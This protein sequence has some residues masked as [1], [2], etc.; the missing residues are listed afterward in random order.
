MSLDS[1]KDLVFGDEARS[2]LMEGVNLLA[3]AVKV[4]MGPKGQ[5]VV[6][7]RSGLPPHLTKDGVTVAQSINL[8]D[9]FP[10]LGV[11]MIKEAANRTAE[12]AGDGTTTATVLSQ[13]IVNEGLKVL[14][15]GYSSSE[16]RKGV[17]FAT[18]Q[19]IASLQEMAVPVSN[20]EEIIQVGTI[21]S[22]GD[23]EIG[24]LL[25]RAM[26]EVGRDGV[27]TVEEA[28]GFN[29]TLDVVE[30][31]ELDRGYLSPYFINDQEKMAAVM[32]G[33]YVLIINRRLNSLQDILPVLEKVHRAGKSLLIVADDIEGDALQGL[34]LNKMKGTLEVCAIRSPEFG[35]ARVNAMGDLAILLGC[36][37]QSDDSKDAMS[38]LGLEDLGS[39]RKAIVKKSTT[40]FVD[41][42]GSSEEIESRATEVKTYL[43]DPTLSQQEAATA[44]RRLSRLSGGVAVMRVGGATEIEL[45]ERRDRVE[46]AL[47][48]TQA[49]VEEGLLPGGGVALVAASK[50]LEPHIKSSDGHSVGARVVREAC[51]APFRQIIMNTGGAPDVILDKVLR[52]KFNKGYDA[53]EERLVDMWDAGIIDPLK[54]VR[55][56]LENASSAACMILSVGCAMTDDED[57]N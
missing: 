15:A 18:K 45:I 47:H 55:S 43:S 7:E 37:V 20:D 10:N 38:S 11:Q 24:E 6:I 21:S 52:S 3:E 26:K 30:G 48:A 32:D 41:G 36:E 16:V 25:C 35:E 46:D 13:A 39:C 2:R 22:N 31:M 14:A 54:V 19:V 9:K 33:P 12:V 40:V 57:K 49:A 5:N 34:V 53:S 42:G 1:N 4:T 29:T 56:A 23:R 17:E 44:R 8:R 51:R 27:I 28:K 50:S